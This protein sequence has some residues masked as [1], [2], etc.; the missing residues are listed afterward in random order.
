MPAELQ[1]SEEDIAFAESVLLPEGKHFDEERR[2]F[3][4]CFETSDLQ[5]VSGSGKTTAL[6]AKLLVLD[7]HLYSA[8]EKGV[9]VISH[10]NAAVNEIRD[11]I[12]VLCP[13]LFAYPN[14]VGTIQSFVDTFL[15]IPSYID[16]FGF[17]PNRIDADAYNSEISRRFKGLQKRVATWVQNNKGGGSPEELIQK[18]RFDPQLNLTNGIGGKILLKSASKSS[19]YKTLARLKYDVIKSG[20]L[21]F[22]DV[23]CLFTD[24]GFCLWLEVIYRICSPSGGLGA[25]MSPQV[26]Y[27]EA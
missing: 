13:R 14:F 2:L 21:H 1:I 19:T 20:V 11:R 18:L 26:P 3:I 6:L 16:S 8:S 25:A 27:L 24:F 5:A 9:L 12:G 4:K 17:R 22:E 7:R 10:T 15:A 23:F